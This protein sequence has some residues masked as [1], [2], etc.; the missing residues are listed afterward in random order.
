MKKRIAMVLLSILTLAL[1]AGANW[2]WIG[3]GR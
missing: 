2:S 3:I 1:T